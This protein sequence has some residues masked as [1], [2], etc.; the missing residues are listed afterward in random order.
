[1][2]EKEILDKWFVIRWVFD[3]MKTSHEI[4]PVAIRSNWGIT[5]YFDSYSDAYDFI[6]SH[7]DSHPHESACT[8]SKLD[9]FRGELIIEETEER[10]FAIYYIAACAN[11][12]SQARLE[13]QNTRDYVTILQ[14]VI[15]SKDDYINYRDDC[16]KKQRSM[17]N[18]YHDKIK[19]L[20]SALEHAECFMTGHEDEAE[21]LKDENNSLREVID[22]RN[23]IIENLRK[24][25]DNLKEILDK[26]NDLTHPF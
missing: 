3:D 25:N 23:K 26:I 1:M 8:L 14:N 2:T 5:D 21:S 15:K 11:G 17:L 4:D 9:S 12:E 19:Q 18:K 16:I 6:T 20:E 13:L 7:I 24:H 10:P 22:D